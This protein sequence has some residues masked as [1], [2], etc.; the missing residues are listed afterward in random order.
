MS[1]TKQNIRNSVW[2]RLQ[3][4]GEARF[5][6]PVEGRIPNFNGAAR[7]ADAL[8]TLDGYQ[9]ADVLK[10][11]PD[12]PQKPVRKRALRDGKTI[13]VPTPRLKSGFHKLDG[14][15]ISKHDR[16]DA[17]TLKGLS[18]Y[19]ENVP[20]NE[21]KRV[22][23]IVTG[24]VAVSRSGGRIGKGEGYSDLEYAIMKEVGGPDVPV[25]TTVHELQLVD[26]VPCEPHDIVLDLITT[27]EQV[28]ETDT[29]RSKPGGIDWS[30]LDEDD[31]NE[32]PVL[33]ELNNYTE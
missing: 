17:V 6:F 30:L 8:T 28:I 1:D 18:A 33:R 32:M 26:D 22:D 14:K 19:G 3:D 4:R 23:L 12:S 9:R 27:P 2:N 15:Q 10:I 31:L 11:N 20:L 16:S 29:S 21:L 7:A 13:L 24:S 25:V 5:P